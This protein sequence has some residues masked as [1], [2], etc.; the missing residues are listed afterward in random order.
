MPIHDWPRVDAGVFHGFYLG[1]IA[2]LSKALNNGVLPPTYYADAEQHAD[3]RIADVLTLHASPPRGPKPVPAVGPNT[4]VLDAPPKLSAH[5]T[6]GRMPKERQKRRHLVI[7]HVSGHRVVALLELVSP[8]NK[9]RRLTVAQFAAKVEEAVRNEVHVAVVDL[10]PP[11]P[12]A[13]H[14]LPARVWRR[15]GRSPVLLPAGRPLSLGT[16]VAK[17]KPEAYFE[18]L[19]V[20]EELPPFP[21]FLTETQYVNL[22]LADTYAAA[23]AGSPPYLRELLAQPGA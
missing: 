23:F 5:R 8:A 6:D 1:W 7:R 21:L 19:A 15:F 18:F 2:E 20:G 4:A 17:P 13:P 3:D 14:G 12:S 9:D 16:F 11:T 10:F 22:P